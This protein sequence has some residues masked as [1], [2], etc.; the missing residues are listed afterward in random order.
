VGDVTKKAK[1]ILLFAFLAWVF[2]LAWKTA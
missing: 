1:E 2:C